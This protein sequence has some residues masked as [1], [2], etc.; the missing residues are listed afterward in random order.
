MGAKT[1]SQSSLVGLARLAKHAEGLQ[2]AVSGGRTALEA[3][4]V[5]ADLHKQAEE[6]LYALAK[7]AR[8]QGATFSQIGQVFGMS[9]QAAHYWLRTPT[10][11]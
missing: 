6:L 4:N 1:I 7:D 3:L 9:R 5:A 8:R 2:T 11:F 10:L